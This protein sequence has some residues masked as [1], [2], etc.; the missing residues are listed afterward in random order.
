MFSFFLP[1]LPGFFS[2]KGKI[3]LFQFISAK[4]C[5]FLI[6]RNHLA[7]LDAARKFGKINF[8]KPKIKFRSCLD[9]TN[10]EARLIKGNKQTFL[11][12]VVSKLV[13]PMSFI[14][15]TSSLLLPSIWLAVKLLPPLKP[16]NGIRLVIFFWCRPLPP[17][18]P[19]LRKKGCRLWLP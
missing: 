16:G 15:S 9:W 2:Y 7:K 11:F 1:K 5:W 13:N 12:L 4:I 19:T 10:L 18:P 3:L 6:T 14:I 17:F 8:A